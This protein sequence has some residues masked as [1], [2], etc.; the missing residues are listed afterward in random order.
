MPTW[1]DVFEKDPSGMMLHLSSS[2]I[3]ISTESDLL[4]V[5]IHKKKH[6]EHISG[7]VPVVPIPLQVKN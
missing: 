3:K 1:Y 5:M 6:H 7:Y 2:R 4:R